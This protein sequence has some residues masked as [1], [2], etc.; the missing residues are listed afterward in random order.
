MHFSPN[1]AGAEY[2]KSHEKQKADSSAENR[3]SRN[4]YNA[5]DKKK[6]RQ[7]S[8]GTA[9]NQIKEVLG[10]LKLEYFCDESHGEQDNQAGDGKYKIHGPAMPAGKIIKK[11]AGSGK[12]NQQPRDALQGISPFSVGHGYQN[13][14]YQA[15]SGSE[16]GPGDFMA[17]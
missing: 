13:P 11:S 10:G 14:G 1:F 4:L 7:D 5:R 8:K 9:L 6:K 12:Q 2:H 16:G 3:G 15:D 17:D